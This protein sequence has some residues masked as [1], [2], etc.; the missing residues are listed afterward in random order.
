MKQLL[1][2][3][4]KSFI[5]LGEKFINEYVQLYLETVLPKFPLEGVNEVRNYLTNEDRLAKISLSL[6][7]KDIILAA[8]TIL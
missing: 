7:T 2:I 3:E 5:I 6:G 8:V 1:K 4:W